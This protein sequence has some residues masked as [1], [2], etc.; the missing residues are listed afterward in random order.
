MPV[1][2]VILPTHDC[3]ATLTTAIDSVFRQSESDWELRV[4]VDGDTEGR[5]DQLRRQWPD[6]RV[7]VCGTPTQRGPGHAR[8]VG[9]AA[10]AGSLLAYLDHDDEWRPG[11]LAALRDLLTDGAD[12]AVTGASYPDVD[13]GVVRH[14]AAHQLAWHHELLLLNPIAEPSR[15]GHTATAYRRYGPWP[16]LPAGFEDWALWLRMS[17]AGVR[18]TATASRTVIARLS[19]GS[20][21]HQIHAPF[22]LPIAEFTELAPADAMRALAT[23]E[24]A[25]RC[26]AAIAADAAE[27]LADLAARGELVLPDDMTLEAALSAA[28]CAPQDTES[29]S[30]AA[31]PTPSPA[32]EL[33]VVPGPRASR[34]VVRTPLPE[35]RWLS[36]AT[37]VLRARRHRFRGVV[38]DALTDAGARLLWN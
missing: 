10:A 19:T 23:P 9:C 3:P 24:L 17:A 34:L 14:T 28:A 12:M 4:I 7:V 20:R 6:P 22:G 15:T 11:H 33:A 32:E 36:A 37:R 25:E 31:W 5:G 30:S 29:P 16:D 21:R 26:A 13:A 27:W 18:T 35:S 38:L 8:Q 1:F 2:T